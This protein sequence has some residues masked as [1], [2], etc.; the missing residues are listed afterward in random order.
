[1]AFHAEFEITENVNMGRNLV[2]LKNNSGYSW[3]EL[4][5]KTGIPAGTLGSYGSCCQGFSAERVTKIEK[6]FHIKAG[7]L[8][9]D[10]KQ[11]RKLYP[12]DLYLK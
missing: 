12:A 2:Y 10:P 7:D 9:K 8:K 1:M 5:E 6:F 3:G 4:A 11:F